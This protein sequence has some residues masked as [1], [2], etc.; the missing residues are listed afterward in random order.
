MKQ[1]VIALV[2][3]IFWCL[4]SLAFTASS[5]P[6]NLYL[7]HAVTDLLIEVK[8]KK[9]KDNGSDNHD[10]A[11]LSNCTI[12]KPGESGGCLVGFKRVCEELKSGNKCCG[13]VADKNATPV[14]TSEVCGD[15]PLGTVKASLAFFHSHPECKQGGKCDQMATAYHCCCSK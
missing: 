1:L 3:I 14:K 9:N 5:S 15:L 8:N 10:D 6:G 2:A 11:A 7:S 4:P 12:Q 13:C